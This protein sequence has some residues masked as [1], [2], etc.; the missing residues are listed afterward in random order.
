MMVDRAELQAKEGRLRAMMA[1]QGLDAVLLTDVARHRPQRRA[2]YLD[3]G[4]KLDEA[5]MTIGRVAT[6]ARDEFLRFA[7]QGIEQARQRQIQA[8][9]ARVWERARSVQDAIKSIDTNYEPT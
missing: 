5:G 6:M 3:P 9:A 1:R 8:Q 4:Q 2:P 7:I